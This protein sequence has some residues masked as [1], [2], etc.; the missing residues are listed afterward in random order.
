VKLEAL[1]AVGDDRDRTPHYN[2]LFADGFAP[3]LDENLV[4][5]TR[6]ASE[7]KKAVKASDVVLICL[8]RVSVT[9]EGFPSEGDPLRPGCC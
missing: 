9:K 6:W 8:S 7:I 3:W 5:G 4:A 1:I 2:R